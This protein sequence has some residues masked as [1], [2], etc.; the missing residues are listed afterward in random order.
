LSH[1]QL[2]LLVNHFK[3]DHYAISQTHTKS[4]EIASDSKVIHVYNFYCMVM[5]NK[6][7]ELVFTPWP[8]FSVFYLFLRQNSIFTTFNCFT[9]IIRPLNISARPPED[10]RCLVHYSSLFHCNRVTLFRQILYYDH[11][12]FTF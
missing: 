8:I 4:S 12:W 10:Y 6:T 9:M 1:L 2:S 11:L 7:G 3:C 5:I